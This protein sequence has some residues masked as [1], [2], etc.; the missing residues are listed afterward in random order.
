MS[1]RILILT[2]SI[3]PPAY[4]PRI[5]SLCRHLSDSGLEYIVFSDREQGV[6]PFSMPFGQWYQTAYYTDKNSRKYL[7]D[8]LFDARERQFEAYIEA[9]V[10]VRTFDAIF[11]STCY[12]FPLQTTYRLARKYRKPFVVDIRDI[13][14]QW[15]KIPYHTHAISSFRAL[16]RGLHRLFTAWNLRKRNRVLV[17]ANTVITISPWHQQVLSRYNPDT[18]LIY[19]GF[20]EREFYPSDIPTDTFLISYAGKIYNLLFRDPRLLFEALQQLLNELPGLAKDLRLRFHVDKGSIEPLRD[21][22]AAYGLTP[23]CEV[24]GYIPKNE[25]LPLLHRS[26]ILLVLTCQSTPDG[27]HGIM[28]T[29]FYEALGVEKPVLCVR[30]DEECLEQVIRE[31]QAGLAGKEV[32]SVKHFISDQYREWCKNGFTRR[33]VQ[34]KDRFSRTAQSEQ[35]AQILQNL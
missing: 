8:K 3:A 26:S 33:Q 2:D 29:K 15:G 1:K 23:Y 21:M 7:A 9:Q 22:A 27:A 4:A 32:E 17:A 16:N 30:S 11:C 24:S 31:T 18:R 28:G 6:E 14:E 12:Y 25:L 5:V 10:D 19:N 13:A 34:H 35:I 20:D